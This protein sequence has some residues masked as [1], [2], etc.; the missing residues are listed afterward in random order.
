MRRIVVVSTLAVM[1]LACWCVAARAAESTTPDR[2]RLKVDPFPPPVEEEKEPAELMGEYLGNRLRD[3]ADI[4]TIK[5]GWGNYRSIGAQVR[6]IGPLQVGVGNFEGWVFAIDRGCVGTMKEVNIEGG[7]SIYYTSFMAR[8]IIWQTEEAKRRNVFFGDVGEK[9][10][11]RTE[12]LKVYDDENQNPLTGTVQVQLPCLPRLEL[13]VHWGEIPDFFL[14]IFGIDGI[15]VP[16]A[17]HKQAGPEGEK[18][19]RIPAPS[20][21][22]HGQEKYERYE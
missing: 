22:W 1:L 6:V 4:F 19:E 5:L 15:R 7:I 18:G 17:F 10:E 2:D 14:S 21:F 11:L 13:S 12:D 3:L 16:P 8:K 20:F 9:G